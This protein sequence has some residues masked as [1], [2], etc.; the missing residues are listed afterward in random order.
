MKRGTKG[1]IA[2]WGGGAFVAS[3]GRNVQEKGGVQGQGGGWGEGYEEAEAHYRRGPR[4]Q[5]TTRRAAR[6]IRRA[7]ETHAR[8]NSSCSEEAAGALFPHKVD[9]SLQKVAQGGSKMQVYF[10][11]RVPLLVDDGRGRLFPV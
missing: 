4:R 5:V 2:G 3:E 8:R 11:G 10:A 7:R 9:V 6:C 1:V